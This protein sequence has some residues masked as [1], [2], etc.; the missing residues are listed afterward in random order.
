MD[1]NKTGPEKDR[2]W[3]EQQL[4]EELLKTKDIWLYEIYITNTSK[5]DKQV[6]DSTDDRIGGE[7]DS[8]DSHVRQQDTAYKDNRIGG[9]QDSSDSHVR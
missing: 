8:S 5:H 4:Q 3:S 7:Q 2:S 1:H 6:Q 9:E